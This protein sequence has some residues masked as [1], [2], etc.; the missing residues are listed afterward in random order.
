MSTVGSRGFALEDVVGRES[1][2][3]RLGGFFDDEGGPLALWLEGAAGIGKTTL[4]RAGIEL[5]R[6]RGFHSRLPRRRPSRTPRWAI[7]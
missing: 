4:W 5:A 2:L 3:D 7:F 6:R 1:E